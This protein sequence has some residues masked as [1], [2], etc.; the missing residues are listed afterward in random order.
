MSWLEARLLIMLVANNLQKLRWPANSLKFKTY[1]PLVGPTEMQGSCT[2]AAG[3]SRVLFI[4]S[5]Q[6]PHNSIFIDTFY[7]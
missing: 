4:R 6:P 2:A 7:Q 1:R 5:V 3:S